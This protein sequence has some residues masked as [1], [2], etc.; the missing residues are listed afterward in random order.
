VAREGEA[1]AERLVVMEAVV[2]AVPGAVAEWLG[3]ASTDGVSVPGTMEA[4][5]QGLTRA[6][7]DTVSVGVGVA[8]PVGLPSPPEGV[9]VGV[10]VGAKEGVGVGVASAVSVA[11]PA[12]GVRQGVAGGLLLAVALPPAREGVLLQ[13]LQVDVCIAAAASG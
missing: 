3:D 8:R 11:A 6:L 4:V 13:V 7:L 5:L 2:Q 10:G 12:E 1:L 9:G